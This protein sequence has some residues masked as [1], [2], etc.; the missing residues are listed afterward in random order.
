[1]KGSDLAVK[2]S[3]KE[4]ISKLL[5]GY[6]VDPP[7]VSAWKHFYENELSAEG[8]ATEML[9]FQKEFDWDFMKINPRASYYVE[10]WGTRF[11]YSGAP[12][13]KPVQVS[14]A[15]KTSD[16]WLKIRPLDPRTGSFGEQLKGVEMIKNGLNGGLDFLQTVFSPLSVAADLTDSN[17]AFIQLMSAGR[18]LETALENITATL[19]KYVEELLNIGVTGIFFATTEWATRKNISEEQY[20]Q[21]GR[22]Y[23]LRVLDKAKAAKFNIL[24]VCKDYNM[25][26]LFKDYPVDILSWNKHDEGNLDFRQA[27]NLFSQVFLGGIDQNTTLVKGSAQDVASQV[28]SAVADAGEHPLIIAP[29]CTIRIGTPRANLRALK[30][31]D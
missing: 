25:L 1:L 27:D 2:S 31:L 4:R 10:G 24:H 17:E 19:E 14:S 23:D 29:G 3:H 6:Q 5:S 13:E 16:D 15:V 20:L 26:P 11:K 30:G 21:Y 28:D 8:M 9:R 12:D 18:N 22:Q 7:P